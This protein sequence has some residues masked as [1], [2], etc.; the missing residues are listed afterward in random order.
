MILIFFG[1]IYKLL[2]LKYREVYFFVVANNLN[3]YIKINYYH[4][5]SA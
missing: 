5:H 3:L 2:N 1:K 4:D